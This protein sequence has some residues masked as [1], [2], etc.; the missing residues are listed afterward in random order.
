MDYLSM[1]RLIR[2]ATEF[3][4]YEFTVHEDTPLSVN[5]FKLRF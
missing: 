1:I 5:P 2:G 3:I 4:A